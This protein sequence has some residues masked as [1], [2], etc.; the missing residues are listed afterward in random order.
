MKN[1]F[2]KIDCLFDKVRNLP[3][4]KLFWFFIFF[5]SLLLCA[6]NGL[7]SLW[8]QDEGA[9]A[10]FAHNMLKTGHWLIPDGLFSEIHRKPPLHFWLIALSF[11]FFG[12]NEFAVRL[13]S[14]LSIVLMFIFIFYQATFLGDRITRLKGLLVCASL[15]S[16]S[17]YAKISF[18][19]GL[20]LFETTVCGISLIQIFY[21]DNIKWVLYFWFAFSLA[22]LTKGPPIIIFS[23]V[24]M[25]LIF[26][27]HSE[28]LKIFR[29]RPWFFLIPACLPFGFWLYLI[30]L[31]PQGK[32]FIIW[33]YDWYIR[34][35]IGGGV[36]GQTAPAGAHILMILFFYL[37]F[38]VFLPK[39]FANIFTALFKSKRTH[40]FFLSI[41]FISG[42]LIYEFTPS[43]LPSYVLAAHIPLAFSIVTINDIFPIKKI[44]YFYLQLL[45]IFLFYSGL[46]IGL[47]FFIKTNK[48]EIQENLIY[49]MIV[50][51]VAFI[52]MIL[53]FSPK[54]QLLKLILYA[55]FQLVFLWYLLI[56][57]L[58][59]LKDQ[60]LK[61]AQFI[62]KNYP[63]TTGILIAN[64]Y[65]E[66]PSLIFYLN[67]FG[68]ENI[69]IAD[70]QNRFKNEVDLWQNFSKERSKIL[71]ILNK[72]Q[73]DYFLQNEPSLKF[74]SLP[75]FQT[76]RTTQDCYYF[77]EK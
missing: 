41:W 43:K 26:V 72:K 28:R 40:L 62:S 57:I 30:S 71:Y 64:I 19:D 22:L 46:T 18:T 23:A 50:Q 36:L 20:L 73:L 39:V 4:Q 61:T 27:F 25:F 58:L 65:G 63:Q 49:L 52:F 59:P 3:I 2:I 15:I 17:V 13:P 10:L 34:K 44:K 56:P 54:Y 1:P 70:D 48:L 47:Y 75:I 16:L 32:D 6:N 60:P 66:P 14:T 37:P 77:L 9:Y 21:S 11:K 51:V 35:R 12:E 55:I 74:K 24:L 53:I 5:Y 8:D 29:L 45:I 31:E 42:W 76:D 33:L 68:Y 7:I 67:K 38:I 69:R